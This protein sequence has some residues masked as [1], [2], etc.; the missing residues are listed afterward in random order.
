[1]T[2]QDKLLAAQ[3]L[4]VEVDVE[5]LIGDADRDGGAESD[6]CDAVAIGTSWRTSSW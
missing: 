2:P 4:D 3:R 1:M 5:L 6:A